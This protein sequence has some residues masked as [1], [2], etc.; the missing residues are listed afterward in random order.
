MECKVES[1]FCDQKYAINDDISTK[2]EFN[3]KDKK[4]L[5]WIGNV[6]SDSHTWEFCVAWDITT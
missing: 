4:N 2:L 5:L 1:Y 3:P 6:M